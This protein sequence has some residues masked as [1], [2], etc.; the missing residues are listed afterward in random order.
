MMA[1]E[2]PLHAE[3]REPVDASEDA[4]AGWFSENSGSGRL[5]RAV[6]GLGGWFSG[7]S[8]DDDAASQARLEAHLATVEALQERFGS[9]EGV[10]RDSLTRFAAARGDKLDAAA[11]MVEKHLAWRAET[12]PID[13]DAEPGVA[14][15]VAAKIFTRAG[16]D[17]DGRPVL[18]FAASKHRSSDERETRDVIRAMTLVMEAAVREAQA[19]SFRDSS[20]KKTRDDEESDQDSEGEDDDASFASAESA[21]PSASSPR[22]ASDVTH[23]PR[24]DCLTGRFSLILYAPQ[25]TELDLRL[26]AALA[27]TFQDNYPERLHRLYATPTGAVTRV[28]WEAV[29]P[30]LSQSVASKVVLASGGRRPAELRQAMPLKTLREA[31]VALDPFDEGE[32]DPWDAEEDET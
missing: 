26:V 27:S 8:G 5:V 17:N 32:E 31:I 1:V 10:T 28:V 3:L 18:V 30:F 2:E 7:A 22:D 6:S 24:D 21:N 9:E 20:A 25:G 23:H 15:A 29:R 4:P 12:F 19:V 13:P 14:G 16:V 11:A